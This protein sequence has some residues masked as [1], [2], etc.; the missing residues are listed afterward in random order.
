MPK[1]LIQV[2]YNPKIDKQEL[3]LE[4]KEEIKK[5]YNELKKHN[6]S[7]NYNESYIDNENTR[8]ILNIKMKIDNKES[9]FRILFLLSIYCNYFHRIKNNIDIKKLSNLQ[10]ECFK[11]HNFVILDIDESHKVILRDISTYF[12]TDATN[13]EEITGKILYDLNQIDIQLIKAPNL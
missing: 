1:R 5:I 9:Y 8:S 7:E 13:L 6:F 12:N 2:I 10:N 11:K 4:A 3:Y